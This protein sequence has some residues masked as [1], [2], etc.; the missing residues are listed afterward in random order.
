MV[1]LHHSFWRRPSNC[2]GSVELCLPRD[3]PLASTD[4]EPITRGLAALASFF[5]GAGTLEDTLLRVSE[6]AGQVLE[7]DMVGITML[8]NGRVKTG[9]FTHPAAPEIDRAQYES[10][11][12]GPCLDA[13]VEQHVHRIHDTAVDRRWPEFAAAAAAAGIVT[14]LSLPLSRGLEPLGALNLYSRQAGAFHERL[15]EAEVLATQ[16]AILLANAQ[17]YHSA[18]DLNDN[19]NQALAAQRTV[20]YA[21]GILMSTGGRSSDEAFQHLVRASQR[22][23]RKVRDLAA[24]IV[25]R[26]QKRSRPTD[27]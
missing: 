14:T 6:I 11:G 27:E 26:A 16:A 19:L 18:R 24:E 15:A 3:P 9:V 1:R 10:A 7:A 23:N 22:E 25:A 20:D 4:D 5:L 8:T 13:F 21:I 12:R 2:V 17:L